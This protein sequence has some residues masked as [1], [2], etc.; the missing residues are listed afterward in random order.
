MDADQS[1]YYGDLLWL[2]LMAELWH[3]NHVEGVTA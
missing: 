3:R 1:T 2:F